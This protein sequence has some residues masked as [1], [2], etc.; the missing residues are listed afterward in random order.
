M[1]ICRSC[2]LARTRTARATCVLCSPY[3]LRYG[4]VF[5]HFISFHF[6]DCVV[7][8]VDHCNTKAL[9]PL[10]H[11]FECLTFTLLF[12]LLWP[13]FQQENICGIITALS[14]RELVVRTATGVRFNVLVGQLRTGRVILS[15][16]RDTAENAVVF[17]TAADMQSVRDKYYKYSS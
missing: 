9:L 2:S 3:S 8:L 12:F 6:S 15:K 4:I 11:I 1:V 17:Q 7:L 10:L 5:S 16:D 14:H 13:L